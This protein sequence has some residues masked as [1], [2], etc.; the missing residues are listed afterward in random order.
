MGVCMASFLSTKKRKKGNSPDRASHFDLLKF[1][2]MPRFNYLN[3]L[4]ATPS[5]FSAQQHQFD[6]KV[7][8][9]LIRKGT[10]KQFLSNLRTSWVR[11]VLSLPIDSGGWGVT[12]NHLCRDAAFYVVTARWLAWAG[13]LPLEHHHYWLPQQTL[14]NHDTWT[15]SHLVH[16]KTIQTQAVSE[17]VSSS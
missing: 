4:V 8:E 14:D 13:T 6:Y 5:L 10:H 15:L 12:P 7:H 2:H 3:G 16:L 1:C 9:A 11:M 17:Y